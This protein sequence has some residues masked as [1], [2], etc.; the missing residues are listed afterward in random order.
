MQLSLRR[1]ALM[2]ALLGGI[3]FAAAEKDNTV[4]SKASVLQIPPTDENTDEVTGS[5]GPNWHVLPSGAP[6]DQSIAGRLPVILPLSD[7]ERAHIHA[8]VIKLVHVPA[9]QVAD[10]DMATELPVSIPMQEFP[11]ALLDEVP[12]VQPYK[13]VKL[14]DRIWLVS[15]MTRRVVAEIPRYHL[16]SVCA[17]GAKC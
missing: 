9:E 11:E 8:S 14:E 7:E 2:V 12:V 3:G 10:A 16:L 4:N 15:P 6:V 17:T 5:I 13:F 1:G